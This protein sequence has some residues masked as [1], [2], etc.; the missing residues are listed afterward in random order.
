[1][2]EFVWDKH[3]VTG[4]QEVDEQH[5]QLVN[6]INAFG[7]KLSEDNI[8]FASIESIYQQLVSY[9][10]YH[11]D[12]EEKL[13][14]KVG[15]DRR[16]LKLHKTLHAH[17]LDDVTAL[18]D[19]VAPDNLKPAYHLFN[20]LTNWLAFHILGCDQNMGRQLKSIQKGMQPAQAYEAD[21]KENEASTKQPLL[22]AIDALFHL[23]S[24]RNKELRVLNQSL[25]KKV[26]Q[27]TEKLA[28]VNEQL[29]AISVTDLLTD[30]PNRRYAMQML[31]NLWKESI[32]QSQP[33]LC[34][35]IDADHFKE[36]NDTYGHDKGDIVLITLAKTLKDSVRTDDI[37]CR[38]GGDEFFVICPNTGLDSGINLAEEVRKKVDRLRVPTGGKPWHGSVSI[39]VASNRFFMDGNFELLI[40]TADEGLYKAKL[41]GKNCVRTVQPSALG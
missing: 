12:E 13:M 33:L 10:H 26:A 23:V 29:K 1:M 5:H 31:S 30:L 28:Q 14:V 11:F 38:L 8:D 18:Y 35:M 7:E 41:D 17:F 37:V 6:L 4:I 27:R 34:M 21:E 39:G 25:E 32:S 9:S 20:F 22:N 19:E 2:K 36:V 40:K 15:I 3:Y 16:H 24:Q